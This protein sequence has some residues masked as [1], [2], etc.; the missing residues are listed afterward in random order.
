MH[1]YGLFLRIFGIFETWIICYVAGISIIY[2][3]LTALGFFVLRRF[4]VPISREE[5]HTLACSPLVPGVSILAPAYNESLTVRQSVRG[6]LK[7]A[8]GNYEVI[9]INDGSKDDTLN[10]LIDEFRLYKSSRMAYSSLESKT[11]RA[12]YASRDPIR[13]LVIDKLNGGKADS[14]NAGLSYARTPLVAAVDSDSIIEEEALVT[15]VRPFLE[16]FDRTIAV[17]GMIRVANGCTIE[18]GRVTKV[19]VPLAP[20]PIFQAVEYLRAFLAGRVAFGFFN[21]LLII[22]GAF[23]VFRRDA[24][25]EVGGWDTNTVG[26]DMEVVVRLH[27]MMR[28][29]KRDYRVAFVPQSVCWTESPDSLK[30]LRRQ[31]NRWQRGTVEC[32]TKHWKMMLNPKYGAVGMIAFPYFALFEMIG[33]LIET[34]GVI[35]TVAGLLLGLIQRD[36]AILFFIVSVLFG[37]L[38]SVTAVLFEEFTTKR[39]PSLKDLLLLLLAAVVENFGYRQISTVWRTEGLWDSFRGKKKG[40]GEMQRKGFGAAPKSG[41]P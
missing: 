8:Y 27:R 29:K 22:S 15:V 40:W 12:V 19:A 18:G 30:I 11:I 31:R 36:V 33:P 38:L 26:E 16:D 39:Y 25:L 32:L 41:V 14:L 7:L 34:V 6:M 3:L 1:W 10:V 28:D 4:E 9:V 23:G 37:V 20:L 17:G 13:L 5:L 35:L 24:L 2:F 21:A